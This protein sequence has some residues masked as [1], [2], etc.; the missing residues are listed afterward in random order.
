MSS[1]YRN[2][3]GSPV[4]LDSYRLG[5]VR[6]ALDYALSDGADMRRWIERAREELVKPEEDLASELEAD[7]ER[8]AIRA[9][10]CVP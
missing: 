6:A 8:R 4:N 10:G 1:P 2:P 5:F 9:A 7:A 3:D